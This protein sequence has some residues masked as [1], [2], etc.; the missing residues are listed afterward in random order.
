MVYSNAQEVEL[1]LN[2]VSLGRKKTFSETIELPVGA[3]VSETGRFY[4][5][6]RLLWSVPFQPGILTAVAFRDGKEVAR[7]IVRTAGAPAR[8]RLLA[9]RRVIAA[10]GDDLSFIAVRVEDKD[11]NLCPLADNLVSFQVT[12]AGSI[13]AVDNGNAATVESFQADHRMAFNGLALLIVRSHAAQPGTIIIVATGQ[14]LAGAQV[15]VTA[16]EGRRVAPYQ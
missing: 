7:E 10:D 11:G 13:A 14:G 6:Y 9:D 12:G 8:I 2:G 1:L 16:R 5:K 4:S 15:Q 3:D